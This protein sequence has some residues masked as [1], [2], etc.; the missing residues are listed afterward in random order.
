MFNLILTFFSLV[1]IGSVRFGFNLIIAHSFELVVVG[2]LNMALSVGLIFSS[3]VE[4]SFGPASSKFL[5]ETRGSKKRKSFIFI[6]KLSL[7]SPLI[8]ICFL[9]IILVGIYPWLSNVIGVSK[10][11]YFTM[12]IFIFT[13]SYYIILRNI[14]YGINRVKW[15]TIIEIIAD[16]TFFILLIA[17]AINGFNQLIL[18]SFVFAYSIFSII[19]IILLLINQKKIIKG[20]LEEKRIST[21]KIAKRYVQFAG[22]SA[23]GTVAS[24]ITAQ[25]AI[26]VSGIYLGKED[27]AIYSVS[28]SINTILL[29][30]PVALSMVLMPQFSE[31]FGSKKIKEI[32][33]TFNQTTIYLTL[34]GILLIGIC[35]IMAR[36]L[37]SIFGSSFISGTVTLQILLIGI[38]MIII[39]RPSTTVLI[40]TKYVIYPNIGGLLIL[41]FSFSGWIVFVP[42]FGLEG[43]ALGYS[44]GLF[45]GISFIMIMAHKFFKLDLKR[46]YIIIVKNG[47]VIVLITI[48]LKCLPTY[49]PFIGVLLFLTLFFIL[50]IKDIKNIWKILIVE[51]KNKISNNKSLKQK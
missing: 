49:G 39:S 9:I 22:I 28:L 30:L 35:A 47:F 31:Q 15:Y 26:I 41:L 48:L 13:R 8:P 1:F 25:M 42:Y 18:L 17:F 43:I 45:V 10:I 11:V 44:I 16:V 24:L 38:F 37:L 21:K 6:E 33:N 29:F 40:G 32:K 20:L 34:I 36:I 5:A 46:F 51:I 23:F 19:S 27:A 50:N 2:S 14:F 4:T 7:T 12:C 3:L